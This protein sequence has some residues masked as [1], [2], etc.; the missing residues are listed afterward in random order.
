MAAQP[1]L[2]KPRHKRALSD[3]VMFA[4]VGDPMGERFVEAPPTQAKMVAM[5]RAADAA[6]ERFYCSLPL[7]GCG[8]V[9]TV[10]AGA[11]RR[12][13]FRHPKGAGCQ[14][15][16]PTAVRDIYT[17]RM[18]QD[19]LVRWLRHAGHVASIEKYVERRSRVDVFCEPNA[20]IEVQLSG[21]SAAS[22]LDRTAR[23]GGNVTW[24]FGADGVI[25]SRDSLLVEMGAVLVVRLRPTDE[26][27]ALSGFRGAGRR[28][29][30]GVLA[31]GESGRMAIQWSPLAEC[32]FDPSTGLQAPNYA[33]ALAAASQRRAGKAA[34][35][36]QRAARES[37][38]ARR[39]SERMAQ[40]IDYYRRARAVQPV[41]RPPQ[42]SVDATEA[43]PR[44][45]PPEPMPG[46]RPQVAILAD[47]P[48]W[49]AKFERRVNRQGPWP[50]VLAVHDD[51]YTWRT[52]WIDGKWLS[53]LP[54]HL[55]DPGWAALYL[56]TLW[57]D[58]HVAQLVDNELDPH[59]VIVGRMAKLGL[60]ELSGSAGEPRTRFHT[61]HD[62]RSIGTPFEWHQPPA[63]SE[64][65]AE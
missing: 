41:I 28:I 39:E 30:I 62:L 8:A 55:V 29:D 6:G 60:V 61:V 52:S 44:P 43:P 17:H 38:A 2:A 18:I 25:A 23:Y 14:L 26:D 40:R 12:P 51:D 63:W 57:A 49:E 34:A 58:G 21:E 46:P 33:S 16:D 50:R 53:G 42:P 27:A 15:S 59:G 65:D 22:M 24:L 10:V 1:G 36:L 45:M 11:V 47:L 35:A 3:R 37:D 32:A 48:H 56:T 5:K 13:H 20:V 9:L 31:H 4:V 54:A 64:S 7:T 19:E